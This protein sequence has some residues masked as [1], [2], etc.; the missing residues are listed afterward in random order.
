[1]SEKFFCIHLNLADPPKFPLKRGTLTPV[2]P[3]L[4]GVRGDL[5]VPKVTVKHFSNS[6]SKT[7]MEA[8][9][10]NIPGD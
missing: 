7:L 2:P 10:A 6:L 3:F 8:S 4:R 5:K 9:Q 1:M